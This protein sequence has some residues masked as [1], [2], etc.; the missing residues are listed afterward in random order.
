MSNGI[1]GLGGIYSR[2]LDGINVAQRGLTVTSNNIANVNTEGYARQQMLT[3]SR[4]VFGN[5][6]FGG[7]VTV[8]GIRSVVDPFVE[9]QMVNE[10]ADFGTL[11]SR[12][13]TLQ[14]IETV[15]ADV[16]GTGLGG[17][18]SAFFNAWSD[19]SQNPANG[20]LRSVVR[21]RGRVVTEMFQSVSRNLNS[22]RTSLTQAID[23]RVDQINQYCEQIADL[24][25]SIVNASD[26]NVKEELSN[27]R[28]L[29]L[30]K[31]SSEI[32]INYF[33]NSDGAMVVQ[34]EASGFS[35]VNRFESATLSMQDSVTYGG[36][37][38]IKGTLPGSGSGEV[39][40]T[41]RITSGRLAGNLIDRNDVIN[42]QIANLDELAFEFVSQ[43]N[44]IHQN[45]YG[46]DSNTGRNF[47][48]PV[49]SQDGAASSMALDNDILSSLDAIAA[50]G[51][52]PAVTG[53]GDSENAE[54]IV[55]LQA[56][57]TMDGGTKSFSQY[58]SGM[59]SEVGILNNQVKS[60]FTARQGLIDKLQQQRENISGVNLDEEA[61]ELI[62]YQ[63]AF[64]ASARVL[65]VANT[66]LD[67]LLEL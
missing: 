24:N 44:T 42:D 49:G 47:F 6:F 58:F 48:A 35:L 54:A 22:I 60:S 39:D 2:A 52:D 34:I 13:N 19:L 27:Q 50:A 17:A 25:R 66:M 32:G 62:R 11:D 41:D 53:V 65:S 30:Q 56:A 57:L 51:Q 46:L 16:D 10:M 64:E 3:G 61:A 63:K 29:V 67:T 20:A 8:F 9:R 40:L 36:D 37:V 15:V 31:L 55:A 21:E 38:S 45:G 1:G 4:A 5:G 14:N 7:G 18:M 59:G 28:A 43:F 33:E 26:A 12:R 23:T